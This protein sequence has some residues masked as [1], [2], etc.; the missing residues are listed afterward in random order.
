MNLSGRHEISEAIYQVLGLNKTI[1]RPYRDGTEFVNEDL[2]N[3]YECV[4]IF[5]QNTVPRTPTEELIRYSCCRR[6]IM[7][8]F[9]SLL[10]HSSSSTPLQIKRRNRTLVEA[11]RTMLIFSKAPMFLWAEAVATACYT[12]NRSLIHTRHDKTPYELVHDKKP[13]LTFFRVFGALCYPTN[14][15]EVLEK[16]HQNGLCYW[17][18]VGYAPSS[19]KYSVNSA[20][21]TFIYYHGSRL[22]LLQ[23]H[24]PSFLS[25]NN[26]PFITYIDSGTSS[27]ES[28]LGIFKFSRKSPYSKPKNFKSAIIEDCWFQAMQDEITNLIRLQ[29]MMLVC[30]CDGKAACWS[31]PPTRRNES[32]FFRLAN[33]VPDPSGPHVTA[34][35]ASIPAHVKLK[36]RGRRL[37]TESLKAARLL[38][39]KTALRI[40][41][42]RNSGNSSSSLPGGHKGTLEDWWGR[43]KPLPDVQGKGGKNITMADVNVNAPAVQA[44]AMTPP[45][46]K[47]CLASDGCL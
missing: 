23:S 20:V 1:V 24:S 10:F 29:C 12:Q 15:N 33:G 32:R 40:K 37:Y 25:V 41:Q 27:E 19:L 39:S 31:T 2:T 46:I 43:F 18:F 22:H 8:T 36:H 14:D 30:T 45:M 9:Y 6:G 16:L 4:S 7:D 47:S 28:S 13:D 5:H 21:D 42:M 26:H 17:I 35:C 3:Y 38:K 34:S 44:P 11:A